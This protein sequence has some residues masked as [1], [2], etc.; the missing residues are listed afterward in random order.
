MNNAEEKNTSHM[1]FYGE[2]DID[3]TKSSNYAFLNW[4]F[5]NSLGGKDNV[6]QLIQDNFVMGN[7]Y[8]GNAVLSL[9]SILCS[10][11]YCSTADVLIFPIMFDLWHGVELW[12]KSSVDA[13]YYILGM[14]NEVK[15]NHKIYEYLEVLEKELK[16]LGMEQTVD[17]AL[18]ELI[19]L[20]KELQRVNANF[21]FTRYSFCGKRK[22]Q[23][24]NAPLGE[25][26]QWQKK[27]KSEDER[28]HV[29]W[30][31]EMPIVPNTCVDLQE[32]F[33]IILGLVDNFRTFVEYLTLVIA[34]GGQL[35]DDAYKKYLTECEK[36]QKNMEEW[37]NNEGDMDMKAMMKFVYSHIL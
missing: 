13:I 33:V 2:K 19:K 12:L 27:E 24:Y 22:Y 9:Y 5:D 34:E 8:M 11:N 16:K 20:I 1:I 14:D 4:N 37:D 31:S 28:M 7:A 3:Y 26:E 15:K 23:F 30:I 21:D 32:L 18:P 29:D 25:D 35:T 10:G 36:V 6:S 17:I